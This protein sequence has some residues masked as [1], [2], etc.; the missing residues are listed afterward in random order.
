MKKCIRCNAEKPY[1]EFYKA[2]ENKD[3]YNNSC[4]VCANKYAQEHYRKNKEKKLA[5]QKIYEQTEEGRAKRREIAK[6]YRESEKGQKYRKHLEESGKLKEYRQNYYQNEKERYYASNLKRKS[7]KHKVKFTLFQ[8]RQLIDLFN[9]KCANCNH[10]V[11]DTT[12]NNEYKAHIDHII[13]ISKGGDSELSNLQ[14]L[15]R[16]CN[17]TKKD[18]VLI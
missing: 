3:G 1:K 13:P 6:R 16:T 8:R 4:K 9:W 2:K 17:L 10:W 11:H 14:V 7:A 12:E 18:K 5:Q 15:C